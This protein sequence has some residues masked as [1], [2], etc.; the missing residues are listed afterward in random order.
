MPQAVIRTALALAVGMIAGTVESASAQ[1]LCAKLW[2]RV[3]AQ[4][5]R[6]KALCHAKAAGS[7]LPVDAGCLATAEEKLASKWNRAATQGDC[8]TP[9]DAAGAQQVVDAFIADL[10]DV[11]TPTVGA[12]C[13]TAGGCYA[14][15]AID[16]FA[17]SELVGTMG[18]PGS[19]CEGATG[20][21]VPPPA[22]GGSCCT[23]P[24]YSFCS[25][26][27]MVTLAACA[28]VGG[29][30]QLG[31]VCLPSGTCTVP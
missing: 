4:G 10:V 31:A 25:A 24:Q 28:N 27:P 11:L 12:C 5:A 26:G 29:L 8:P 15:P 3:A 30:G 13:E 21:C 20:T 9:A 23:L 14:G 7:G 6:A 22:V 18:P 19:V 2:Y 1:S 16:G 17:C